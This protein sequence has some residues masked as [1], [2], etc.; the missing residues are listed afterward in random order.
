MLWP[1]E[2]VGMWMYF[3]LASA[4]LVAL[5][6]VLVVLLALNARLENRDD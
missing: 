2:R 6:V 4:A 3:V 5:N 1:E